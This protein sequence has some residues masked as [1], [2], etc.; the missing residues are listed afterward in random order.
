[1]EEEDEEVGKVEEAEA[2]EVGEAEVEEEV[3]KVG[4]AEVGEAEVGELRC[5]RLLFAF[6]EV[7]PVWPPRCL[8][9]MLLC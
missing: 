1:M 5:E 4:E 8:S 9:A 7:P 3:G 6:T 2:G